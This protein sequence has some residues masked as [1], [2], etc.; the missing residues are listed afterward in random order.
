[1][2]E[3]ISAVAKLLEDIKTKHSKLLQHAQSG[4]T[5][6]DVLRVIKQ[7]TSGEAKQ[8]SDYIINGGR[9]LD[10]WN[11]SMSRLLETEAIEPSEKSMLLLTDLLYVVEGQFSAIVNLIVHN[12]IIKE[13]HDIWDEYQEKFVTSFKDI[14][15]L[16]L[17]LKLEFLKRHGFDFLAETCPRG[18]RNAIAHQDFKI[19]EDGSIVLSDGKEK[20][21]TQKEL[22][23]IIVIMNEL[24]TLALDTWSNPE[25]VKP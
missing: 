9:N 25:G 8:I 12:K 22:L 1:M 16:R 14:V 7:G 20:R 13:H 3:K 2:Y 5:S 11:R 19:D 24:S 18:L 15:R 6:L 23:E 21:F 4:I 17:H 10:M